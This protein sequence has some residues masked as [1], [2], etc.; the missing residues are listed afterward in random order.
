MMGFNDSL[1]FKL[2]LQQCNLKLI[3]KGVLSCQF[4]NKR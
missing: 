3:L 2:A 4:R 1:K